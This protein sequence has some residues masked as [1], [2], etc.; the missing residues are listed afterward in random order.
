V[1]FTLQ[2]VLAQAP[3][4]ID[5]VLA[6]GEW[7]GA[8]AAAGFVQFEPQRGERSPFRT[9]V[10]VLYDK[11]HVYVSLRA[12]DPKPLTAQ[13][14]QRDADLTCDDAVGVLIDTFDDRQDRVLFCSERAQY[15]RVYR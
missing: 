9:D 6:D 12:W 2:T 11:Q 8:P 7:D 13:L 14:T 1:Q 4:I 5:G 10:R 15:V 3:P